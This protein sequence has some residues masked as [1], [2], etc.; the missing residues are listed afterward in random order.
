[1]NIIKKWLLK[2]I[3]AKLK[4]DVYDLK[5]Q[6][7]T[8]EGRIFMKKKEE[9]ARSIYERY[10]PWFLGSSGYYSETLEETIS[11]QDERIDAIAKFLKISFE[12]NPAKGEELVVKPIKKVVAQRKPKRKKI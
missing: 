7:K 3:K 4:S 1:M 5:E 12:K 10:V 8:L 6:I 11:E 2:D 9:T